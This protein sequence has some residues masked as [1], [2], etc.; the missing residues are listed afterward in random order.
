[1][2]AGREIQ[3][4]GLHP[5][6]RSEASPVRRGLGVLTLVVSLAA[7]QSPPEVPDAVFWPGESWPVSSP[8]A[9]GIRASALDS[10]VADMEAGVYGLVDALLVIRHGKVVADHRFQ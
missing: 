7:C 3:L 1:M 5:S 4:P 9:E 6:A 10:L 2:S 8:E